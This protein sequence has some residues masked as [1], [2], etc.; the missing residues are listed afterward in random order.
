MGIKR[1]IL[2]ALVSAVFTCASRAQEKTPVPAFTG[3]HLYVAD[4]AE[5]FD[6]VAAQ[7]ARLEKSSHQTY[8]VVVVRSFGP[9]PNA[10]ADYVDALYRTWRGQASAQ[11]LRLDP[12]RSVI[13]ALAIQDRKVLAHAGT[14]IK[15]RYGWNGPTIETDLINPSFLPIAKQGKYSEAVSTLLNGIDHW[16]AS[17]ERAIAKRS[18]GSSRTAAKGA[19]QPSAPKADPKAAASATVR[20]AGASGFG[21]NLGLAAGIVVLVLVLSGAVLVWLAHRQSR[22]RTNRRI[23]EFRAKSVEVMDRLDALKERLKLLPKEDADFR[24]PISGETLALYNA[25][26]SK[27]GAL[28]D[29]WLE[30]MEALDKAQKLAGATVSPLD[31]KKL[32]EAEALLDPKE[33][34]GAIETQAQTCAS[35]MDRLNQAHESARDSLAANS[36]S[37]SK[38][39]AQLE[40]AQKLDLPAAPYAEE[41][42]AVQTGSTLAK[43]SMIA[44]PIGTRTALLGL[45]ARIEKLRLR[46]ERVV[47]LRAD[48]QR[49]AEA[50]ES[51]K[52]QVAGERAQGLALA[53]EGG[54]PDHFLGRAAQFLGESLTALNAGDPDVA[55]QKLDAA[56][57]QTEQGKSTIVEVQKAKSYCLLQQAGRVRETERLRA[58]MPEA[59]SYQSQL[60]R[61]FAPGSWQAVARNLAQARTMLAS[62]DRL[63]TDAAAVAASSSQ[64]YLEGARTLEQLAQQQQ[65]VLRLMSG[66]GEQVNA[67]AAVRDGCK[68]TRSGLDARFRGVE[69]YLR[70]NAA[71]IGDLPRNSFTAAAQIRD[72]TLPRFGDDRPDWPSIGQ[73][74]TRAIEELAIAQ[75]Q[76]ETDVRAQEQLQG[77]FLRARQAAEKVFALLAGHQ[78]DRP[79]ANQ[80]YQAA[81]EALAR[82]GIDLKAPRGESA[83]M[84]DQVRGAAADLETARRMAEEDIRLA[85]QAQSELTEATRAIRK[86][87]AFFSLGVTVETSAAEAELEQ[88]SRLLQIREYEQAIAHAGA[89]M[90]AIRLAHNSAVQQAEWRQMQQDAQMRRANIGYGTQPGGGVSFGTIAAGTAASIILDQLN[91]AAAASA[92]PAPLQSSVVVPPTSDPATAVGSWS[93]DDPQGSW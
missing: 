48:A 15:E 31:Q 72:E 51:V 66:L 40:A 37:Q 62:F 84:L 9:G 13:I 57:A 58:A 69:D 86:A 53:E 42:K 93:S 38:L 19:Q 35:D 91:K 32:Q 71:V 90:G 18:A 65:I 89:A 30:I 33:S 56:R 60:E 14:T 27:L 55:G 80:H 61:E 29:R 6:G 63:A 59:E 81:D 75:S 20:A 83:R 26:Q 52:R 85:A 67:L 23:K 88:A 77:E 82:V 17:K 50:I 70:Q 4:V 43:A 47:T 76:A 25:V 54:N 73:G 11:G 41:L 16:I 36:A 7:I 64:R 78:E 22:N 87:K 92:A 74:L 34:F 68:K 8:Y 2:I 10:A 21:Q 46:V 3:D 79:A 24:E 45:T 5:R 28:W 1:L 44:D 39:A 12:E 49:A